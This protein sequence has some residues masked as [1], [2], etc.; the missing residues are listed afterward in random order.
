MTTAKIFLTA[1]LTLLG[2]TNSAAQTTPEYV[3]EIGAGVGVTS[4]EGDLNGSILRCGAPSFAIVYR[5]LFNPR[6]ALA[7]NGQYGKLKASSADTG[8]AYPGI[9]TSQYD[10]GDMVR[11]NNSFGDITARAEYNFW[12]YGT[13]GDYRGAKRVTPFVFAGLGATLVSASHGTVLTATLP[14]GFGVKVKAAQRVNIALTWDMRFTMS[15]KLDSLTDPYGV[16]R[17]GV[18]KNADTYSTLMLSVTYSFKER[19]HTC[20]ND[21]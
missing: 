16:Q 11:V 7:I 9:R 5:Y 12:P 18:F 3:M 4:Y 10:G 15:D 8:T 19:C 13:G 14:L 20:H 1:A 6:M 2:V 21:D 17:S